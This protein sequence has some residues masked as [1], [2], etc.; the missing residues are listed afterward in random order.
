MLFRNTK[1]KDI[2]KGKW[3]GL[4]GKLELSESPLEGA[5]RETKEEAG[6]D[7]PIKTLKPLGQLHFPNFKPDKKEDWSVSVFYS[8]ISPEQKALV[9]ESC[10]EGTLKW[11]PKQ[12]L[13]ELPLWEG[14]KIF[15]PFVIQKKPFMGC[16][17][18]K[19]KILDRHWIATLID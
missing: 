1:E 18:Y 4:G 9:K 8:E 13:L 12:E 3:N 5:L 7:L 2:H 10:P 19:N 16:F 6:L 17:W 11:V 15:L 14:D